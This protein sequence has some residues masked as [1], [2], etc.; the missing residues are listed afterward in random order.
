MGRLNDENM[1]TCRIIWFFP[2]GECVQRAAETQNSKKKGK[3]SAWGRG[4]GRRTGQKS[5]KWWPRERKKTAKRGKGGQKGSH[6][7]L[8]ESQRG[9][10]RGQTSSGRV[11]GAAPAGPVRAPGG[12][13]GARFKGFKKPGIRKLRAK[14]LTLGPKH[15]QLPQ[16][17]AADFHLLKS[18]CGESPPPPRFGPRRLVVGSFVKAR[19]EKRLAI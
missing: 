2:I 8:R 6:W 7:G 10:K 16:A 18:P 14:G 12:M 3:K 13:R 15:A 1:R 19:S 17:G 9:P 4:Q 11:F 5:A